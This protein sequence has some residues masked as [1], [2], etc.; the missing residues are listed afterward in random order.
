[1]END[2][3]AG[4]AANTV[5]GTDLWTNPASQASERKLV[6]T[7]SVTLRTSAFEDDLTALQQLVTTVGGYLEDYYQSGD[8]A[9]GRLRSATFTIRVPAA[10]LD[11]FLGSASG[12]ARVTDRSESA[13]DMSAQYYDNETRLTTLNT[14]MERLQEMLGQAKKMEDIITIENAISD[15]QY[16]I[17]SYQ[18]TQKS[19]DNR[20]EM[21]T[22]TLYLKEEKAAEIAPSE[23][24]TFGKRI[25]AAI[26]AGWQ[27]LLAFGQNLVI[28]LLIAFPYLLV[29]A[30]I[31]AVIV[32]I[33][34][35][36][37]KKAARPTD[38]DLE[39]AF[40]PEDKQ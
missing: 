31:V 16:L 17:D 40:R 39:A 19:I 4:A 9:S 3:A 6:R 18:S 23:G 22:V 29:A 5:S 26:E 11:E 20:V 27:N 8:T 38:A 21:S 1:M 15:T 37:R 34:K 24:V 2:Y 25:A 32:L 10:R 36:R 30:V 7:A 13:T 28:F 12:I 33:V 14:K 35:A